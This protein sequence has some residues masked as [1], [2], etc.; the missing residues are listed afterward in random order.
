MLNYT[1]PTTK[2]LIEIAP[3]K[4]ANLQRDRPTFE[5]FPDRDSTQFTMEWVQKD[6]WRGFQQ[7]RGLNG[8]PAYVSM[9]GFKHFSAKPGI[10]GEFMTID[11]EMLTV[12][13]AMTPEGQPVDIEDLVLE[14]QEILEARETD[15]KEFIHWQALLYGQFLFLGP[16]G[17]QYGDTFPIQ[18]TTFSDWSDLANATPVRDLMGLKT[19]ASGKSVSF[20]TGTKYF[21]NAKMTGYL[22]M[23]QNAQDLGGHLN[24]GTTGGV[25]IFKTLTEINTVLQSL[26]LGTIVEYDEDYTDDDGVSHKWIPDDKISIVGRRTNGDKL[27]EYRLVRNINNE[28]AAPG[29]YEKVIDWVDKRVPRLIEVHRGHNGGLVIYYG[30]AI[31]RANA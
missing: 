12:R 18:T 25:R 23:N 2:E 31:V 15:L 22:M 13:A 8:E 26:N 6:G 30:S 24:V 14:R 20:G 5:I 21:M 16:T 1:Y 27:G 29:A 17:A 19:L 11:E 4:I 10:Y 28:N 7:L 3:E 9:R